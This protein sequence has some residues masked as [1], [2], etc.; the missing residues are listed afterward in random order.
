MRKKIMRGDAEEAG[1]SVSF[2][3]N[4]TRNEQIVFKRGLLF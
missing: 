4:N 1:T 2:A 3:Q